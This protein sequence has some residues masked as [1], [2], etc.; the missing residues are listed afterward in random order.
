MKYFSIKHKQRG[1]VLLII[2]MLLATV[3]TVVT[4]ISFKSTT[5]TQVSKLE[6]ESQKTL[7]AA[8]AGIEKAI[9]DRKPAGSYVFGPA[10]L[11]LSNLSGI[12]PS[13]STVSVET[14][15]S[16]GFVTPLIQKDQQ[17]TFY[18]ANY[19]TLSDTFTNPFPLPSAS[20]SIRIGYG[21]EGPCSN[22]ALEITMISGT[23]PYTVRRYIA[24]AGTPGM[25][26][27]NTDDVYTSGTISIGGI[28]F[29]CRTSAIP[30][31]AANNPKLMLVRTIGDKSRIGILGSANLRP[32]GKF[33]I[34]EARSDAGIVKKIQLF[35]SLP[36]IPA[37]FF[38]STF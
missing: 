12:D 17:Y 9:G 14:S 21:T 33:I 31:V 23:A 29:N 25:L 10:G 11:D 36:Q 34:S 24:D 27:S 13:A 26:S 6:E 3:I 1:Q 38:V 35:Q 32:Q 2:I 22:L 28:T 4:T 8:E 7:A 30:V 20:G 15:V 37:E 18:L 5:E 19:D 16:T